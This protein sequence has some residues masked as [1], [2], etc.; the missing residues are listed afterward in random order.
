LAT[1]AHDLVVVDKKYLKFIGTRNHQ[2]SNCF[3]AIAGYFVFA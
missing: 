1:L 2:I 3:R